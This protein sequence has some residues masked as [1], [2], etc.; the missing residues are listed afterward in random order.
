MK[1]YSEILLGSLKDLSDKEY[2]DNIW[3]NKNNPKNLVSS[4]TES[5]NNFLGDALI[6]D[7]LENNE[8]IYDKKVTKALEELSVAVDDV[9]EFRHEEEIINDPKMQIVREKAAIALQLILAS[10][11]SEST[12]EIVD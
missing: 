2:Q 5:A 9:N 11:G 6:A 7:A 10:D 4:F 8:I 1:I 12:V 3:L